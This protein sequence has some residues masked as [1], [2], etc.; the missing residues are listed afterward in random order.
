MPAKTETRAHPTIAEA[1][2]KSGCPFHQPA[3]EVVLF[4]PATARRTPASPPDGDAPAVKRASD[5][6]DGSASEPGG[7]SAPYTPDA[8]QSNVIRSVNPEQAHYIFFR[9]TDAGTFRRFVGSL[10]DPP[11]Q[12]PS[13][14]AAGAFLGLPPEARK[15]WSEAEAHKY[16]DDGKRSVAPST[17]NVAFTWTG[18][19]ALGI[20]ANTLASFPEDFRDGMA[21]RAVR[22]GDVGESAPAHWE[23][24]LGSRE[25]HGVLVVSLQAPPQG[26]D[27]ASRL[28]IGLFELPTPGALPR[29]PIADLLDKLPSSGMRI[30]HTELGKRIPSPSNP[31]HRIEHFGFRDG[32]SQPFAGV[33]IGAL[34]PPPP[35]G[36]TPRPGGTWDPIAPGELL[37]GHPDEDGLFQARPANE[38]LRQ[39]GTYMVFRKLEQD[40][41][42]FR[43]YLGEHGGQ[44]GRESVLAAQM[45]GRWPDGTSLAKST[46]W[47]TDRGDDRT[48]NDFRYESEDPRGLRCPLGSHA[49]RVNP[50]DSNDR[51][52][53][54]RHRIWRRSITYGDFLPYESAGDGRSRGLLFVAMC[55]RIDQQFEF[56]QT[57]WL[58]TGE[59]I[60]QAGIGRCPVTGSNGGDIEDTFVASGRVAPYTKLP[61]FVKVLGGDYFFMPSLPALEKIVNGEKFPSPAGER[62]NPSLDQT[63]KL[64]VEAL[65]QLGKKMLLPVGSPAWLQPDPRLPLVVVGRQKYVRRILADDRRFALSAMDRRMRQICGG[66]RLMLGMPDGDPDRTTRVKMWIDAAKLQGKPSWT[67]IVQGALRAILSRHGP[68]GALDIVRDVSLVVPMA[69]A[70]AYFGV[71]GPNWISPAFI[72][73][74]FAKAEISQVPRDWLATLPPVP[75]QDVPFTTLQAWA[76]TAFAHVF[77]NVV[78]AAELTGLAQRTT[79]EFFRHLDSLVA[80]I[81]PRKNPKATLLQCFMALDPTAYGLTPERFAV[82]VRLILAEL[83]VGSAGTLAEALPNFIEYLVGHPGIVDPSRPYPDDE[84]DAIVREA[85]RFNPVAP[86]VFRQCTADTVLGGRPISKGATVAVLLK[87]AMFDQRVFADPETFSTDP[88]KRDPKNYLVFGAGL[89]ECKGASIGAPVVREMARPLIALGDLRR[90]AG[91]PGT[92]RDPLNR[93]ATL[94]VRFNPTVN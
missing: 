54:R 86:V 23:G 92:E 43:R 56:L 25:V 85:L 81:D 29:T 65:V 42:A 41:V 3:G 90:A 67:A 66:E 28:A 17:W 9:I 72:A 26:D 20:E 47:P 6:M 27:L 21:A 30:L 12:Q 80:E 45:M 78:D 51:D 50:R 94:K 13:D 48:V 52:E 38:E 18:L 60:G 84:L 36:G 74:Q 49:R 11:P 68:A 15:F 57:R 2:A 33:D 82:V 87:T 19:K 61:R 14:D 16:D 53:A 77:V 83:I 24:W 10:A 5:T 93:W 4:T 70:R 1:A 71:S 79:A 89:H 75:P 37:L 62:K 34:R 8:V 73:S 35:G 46:D 7:R 22:L 55:A 39:D 69:L 44:M 40:V 63:P 64:D 59:F 88:K 31:D 91:P 76:Q 58:N 32:V